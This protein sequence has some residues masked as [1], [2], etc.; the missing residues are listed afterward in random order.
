MCDGLLLRTFIFGLHRM[1]F[2]F[3]LARRFLRYFWQRS[4]ICAILFQSDI[5]EQIVFIP[6]GFE[7][8]SRQGFFLFIFPSFFEK[9][10][11][12][13]A[14]P[15]GHQR[16]VPTAPGS[17]FPNL[18]NPSIPKMEVLDACF[19]I[20]LRKTFLK[21]IFFVLFPFSF[22]FYYIVKTEYI[23]KHFKRL[24]IFSAH[25]RQRTRP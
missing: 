9:R 4:D 22:P 24:K 21:N 16:V 25:K 20:V 10:R 2:V 17:L 3:T 6:S 15:G 12:W 7:Q 18:V 8:T 1:S 14:M 11:F 13:R 19:K 23:C 5:L